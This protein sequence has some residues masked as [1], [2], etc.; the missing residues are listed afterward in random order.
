ML[1]KCRAYCSGFVR[2][3]GFLLLLM[4]QRLSALAKLLASTSTPT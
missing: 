3:E 2:E 4:T 1:T